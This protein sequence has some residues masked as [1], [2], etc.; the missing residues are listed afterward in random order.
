MSRQDITDLIAFVTVATER[1]FTRGAAKLGVSPSALSHAVRRF[2]ERLGLRVLA[3]TTRSVSLTEAGER[4][5]ASAAPRLN[6]IDAEI[7]ALSALRDKPAG[8]IRITA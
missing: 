3:R 1:S 7:E 6:E 4:L 5:L 8:S 2:E